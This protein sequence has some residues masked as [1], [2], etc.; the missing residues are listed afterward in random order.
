MGIDPCN[1]RDWECT[2]FDP[3][4][5]NAMFILYITYSNSYFGVNSKIGIRV[6]NV[7]YKLC[8]FLIPCILDSLTILQVW[9]FLDVSICLSFFVSVIYSR[10]SYCISFCDELIPWFSCLHLALQWHI[11]EHSRGVLNI[12]SDEY[13]SSYLLLDLVHTLS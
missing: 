3:Q 7:E 12:V 10:L 11:V 5:L 6:C 8:R 2:K 9:V 13:L 1:M 4:M